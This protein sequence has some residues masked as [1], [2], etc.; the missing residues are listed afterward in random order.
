[1]DFYGSH[2][3]YVRTAKRGQSALFECLEQQDIVLQSVVPHNDDQIPASMRQFTDG[4]SILYIPILG[5]KSDVGVIE[6]HGLYAE[7]VTDTRKA[8]RP[9]GALQAMLAAKDYRFKNKVRFWRKPSAL[10][11]GT[12][13]REGKDRRDATYPI[14]CGRCTDWAVEKNGIAYFGG[15]RF[16]L[17]WEDGLVEEGLTA[18]ALLKVYAHT[19]QSMGSCTVLDADVVN[20]LLRIGL[21]VGPVFEVRRLEDHLAALGKTLNVPD[22]KDTTICE[23]ALETAMMAMPGIREC[24]VVG[25]SELA[26]RAIELVRRG[27]DSNGNPK[28]N[29][30][31]G[32]KVYSIGDARRLEPSLSVALTPAEVLVKMMDPTRRKDDEGDLSG[33]VL[34]ALASGGGRYDSPVFIDDEEFEGVEG[35][36]SGSD[37]HLGLVIQRSRNRR[38]SVLAR[39]G[40]IQAENDDIE[41]READFK[42][43]TEDIVDYRPM[44]V[45]FGDDG[46]AMEEAAA[47]TTTATT[48]NTTAT[49][50]TITA[51]ATATAA[52]ATTT[53][54]AVQSTPADRPT[55]PVAV[56]SPAQLSRV[57]EWVVREL[58]LPAGYAWTGLKGDATVRRVF[59]L[60]ARYKVCGG[61]G[62][63][64]ARVG[65]DDEEGAGEGTGSSS[66]SSSGACSGSS[67]SSGTPP[68]DDDID[69]TVARKE[70]IYPPSLPSLRED[71]DIFKAIFDPV[72]ASI[73]HTAQRAKRAGRRRELSRQMD[74]RLAGW[75]ELPV[76]VI[77]ANTIE[78]ISEVRQWGGRG[79]EL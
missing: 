3:E 11:G 36:S 63:V 7:G 78:F 69:P 37:A 1:M 15:A 40:L 41:L 32:S 44:R 38:P 25:L 19:P 30:K 74:A 73:V 61:V 28:G 54:V 51:T 67:G 9:A 42:G 29:S 27:R 55:A 47:A 21:S 23:R 71:A 12:V 45:R 75:S 26:N 65:V 53:A 4:D 57:T 17:T 62:H 10:S 14:V 43:H 6:I 35:A 5:R 76:N 20:E 39:P 24:C 8:Q 66:S 70:Y 64:R 72:S 16:T 33:A 18:A 49:T 31:G 77:C 13:V 56:R 34:M 58:P 79:V 22:L 2:N 68:G 46:R 60:V 48:A 50:I 52:A 59:A